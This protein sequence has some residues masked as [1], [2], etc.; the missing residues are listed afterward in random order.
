[1]KEKI[2]DTAELVLSL[3][4]TIGS[5]TIF[6]ACDSEEGRHMACHWAQNAFAVIGIVL[7]LQTFAKMIIK[8]RGIKTGLAISIFTLAVAV[9][10]IPGTA[11]NLCMMK[12]MRCHTVFR[13]AVTVTASLLA[14][15]S[16]ID[17]VTN[18]KRMEKDK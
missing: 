1:M 7:V 13:P 14:V 10:F 3:L 6:R 17:A 11:I 8:L 9:I 5:L 15:V 4:L 16:L 18:F 12:T 2:Y